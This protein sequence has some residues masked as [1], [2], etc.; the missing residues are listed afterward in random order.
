[1]LN[2][3]VAGSVEESRRS[4]SVADV[5]KGMNRSGLRLASVTWL[6]KFRRIALSAGPGAPRRSQS[7]LALLVRLAEYTKE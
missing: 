3:E 5:P 4:W 6:S 1:M 2:E 7:R